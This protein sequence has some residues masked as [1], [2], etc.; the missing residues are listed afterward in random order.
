MKNPFHGALCLFRLLFNKEGHD[1]S[2]IT[3]GLFGRPQFHSSALGQR[4]SKTFS[5]YCIRKEMSI[6]EISVKWNT[7]SCTKVFYGAHLLSFFL[8]KM[9]Q[10]RSHENDCR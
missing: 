4:G 8:D 5:F 10:H 9:V 6:N 1:V 7:K 2:D 3:L